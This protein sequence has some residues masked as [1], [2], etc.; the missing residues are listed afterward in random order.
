M[1]R[2]N[3][4]YNQIGQ[5]FTVHP[6]NNDDAN[7]VTPLDL[8]NYAQAHIL[9]RQPDGNVTAY[10]ATVT[11]APEINKLTKVFPVSERLRSRN[12]ILAFGFP[13]KNPQTGC[14]ESP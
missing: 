2:R 4:A 12:I 6:T 3:I 14:G 1:T 8:T 5:K 9:I 7:A 13:L 11:G 10:P